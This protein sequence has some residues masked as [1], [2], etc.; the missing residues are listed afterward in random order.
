MNI[1]SLKCDEH[2]G[3]K[4]KMLL[5]DAYVACQSAILLKYR[6]VLSSVFFYVTISF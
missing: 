4:F 2:I 5:L 3:G 1:Q 6:K